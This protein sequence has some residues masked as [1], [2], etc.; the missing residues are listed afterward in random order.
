MND[1]FTTLHVIVLLV[2]ISFQNLTKT[3]FAVQ[4]CCTM[5]AFMLFITCMAPVSSL[6]C[7]KVFVAAMFGDSHSQRAVAGAP[8]LGLGGQ[9]VGGRQGVS[10]Q[11]PLQLLLHIA[12]IPPVTPAEH[13]KDRW[14]KEP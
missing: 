14:G 7:K 10:L 11:P 5:H 4:Q 1:L 3:R 2:L 13:E 9:Q 6:L 12:H 8:E